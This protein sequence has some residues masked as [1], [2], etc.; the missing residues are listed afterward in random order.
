VF[1]A[2][3][4]RAQPDLGYHGGVRLVSLRVERR[5]VAVAIF[6]GDHLEYTDVRQLSSSKDKAS[7]SALGF[8][9]WILNR[10]PVDSA[11]VEIAPDQHEIQRRALHDA[12]CK[13]L[14]EQMLPIWEVPRSALLSGTG[15]PPLR[16]R[17]E[18][19]NIATTI[20]PIL[21]GTHGKVF[22]Q[23]AAIL[24]L[25]VQIERLFIIS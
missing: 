10:F 9:C 15:H 12:F 3:L 1:L 13:A 4:R 17:A 16:S 21:A 23:E 14:R 7:A 20:W 25:H 2:E 18:L 24:G 11:A 22:I 5:A 8:V 19:R 6:H